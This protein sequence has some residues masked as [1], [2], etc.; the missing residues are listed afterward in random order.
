MLYLPTEGWL[1]L[2]FFVLLIYSKLGGQA[3]LAVRTH[4]SKES[5]IESRDRF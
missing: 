1:L 2:E 4:D 5:R 3:A